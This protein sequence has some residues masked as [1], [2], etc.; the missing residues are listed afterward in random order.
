M[1]K[2][3]QQQLEEV[4]MSGEHQLLKEAIIEQGKTINALN[5]ELARINAIHGTTPAPDANPQ[6]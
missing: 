2:N 4:L 1:D 6:G 5:A 3:A